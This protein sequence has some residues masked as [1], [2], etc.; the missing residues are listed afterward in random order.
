[1][2]FNLKQPYTPALAPYELNDRALVIDTETIGSGPTIEIIEIAVGDVAG[3]I[4]YESLVHPVFN[5]L[6]KPSKHAR[7]DHAAF[8]DAPYWIDIWP[9]VAALID[10]KLLV[11]YNASF[12]RRALAAMRSRHA[13]APTERG[14]RCAMQLVKKLVGTKRSLTLSEACAHFGLEGGNHRA[15]RDVEVTCRLLHA[16]RTA[17]TKNST[18][19]L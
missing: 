19:E 1:M 9:E 14:W 18:H 17:Q 7:F 2:H 5:R 6:P 16:L 15:A 12:D 13:H 3:N 4:I 8:K 11:A 10:R